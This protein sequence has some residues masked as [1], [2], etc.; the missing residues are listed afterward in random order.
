MLIERQDSSDVQVPCINKVLW[1]PPHETRRKD[2]LDLRAGFLTHQARINLVFSAG[3][4][5]T[6]VNGTAS[7]KAT[8]SLR[9]LMQK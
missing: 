5:L 1:T 7:N 9:T 2:F 8:I 4:E 3:I 6:W